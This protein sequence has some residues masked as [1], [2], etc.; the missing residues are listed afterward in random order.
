MYSEELK[1]KRN[2]RNVFSRGGR[3]ARGQ[4]RRRRRRE[5]AEE[6]EERRGNASWPTL[7]CMKLQIFGIPTNRYAPPGLR[8]DSS[9]VRLRNMKYE[10][11][12]FCSTGRSTFLRTV[13]RVS[14]RVKLEARRKRDVSPRNQPAARNERNRCCIDSDQTPSLSRQIE[15][16]I[17]PRRPYERFGSRNRTTFL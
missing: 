6:S 14:A 13:V 1:K 9:V 11:Y 10:S 17:D 8:E 4:R 12:F 15:I 2:I 5:R 3:G 16:L 7:R